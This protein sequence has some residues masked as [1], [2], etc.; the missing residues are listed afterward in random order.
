MNE[1]KE[2]NI[3]FVVPEE[4]HNKVLRMQAVLRVRENRKISIKETY[5]RLIDRGMV[6]L[7]KTVK[8]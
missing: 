2:V 1:G 4:M 8:L 7:N 5:I 3:R 6:E